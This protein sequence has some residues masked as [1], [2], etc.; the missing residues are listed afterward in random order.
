V[1]LSQVAANARFFGR[2][3]NGGLKENYRYISF[4][5]GECNFPKELNWLK[6]KIRQTCLVPLLKFYI[7]KHK[8]DLAG[9][10]KDLEGYIDPKRH[11]SALET[12]RAG[13]K[14]YEKK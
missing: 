3:K 10:D 9:K 13:F 1:N 11:K 5:V 8:D 2:D 4:F 7:E 12:L 6:E 14:V